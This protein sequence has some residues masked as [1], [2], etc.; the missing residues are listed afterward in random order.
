MSPGPTEGDAKMKD[1]PEV[2]VSNDGIKWTRLIPPEKKWCPILPLD[3][4]GGVMNCVKERC[5]LWSEQRECCGL[6]NI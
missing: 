2:S 1:E 4:E 5:A 3:R 6:I